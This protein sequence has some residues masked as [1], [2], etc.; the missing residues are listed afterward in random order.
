MIGAPPRSA[1]FPY[2]TLFRSDRDH[3]IRHRLRLLVPLRD[4]GRGSAGP[5]VR[6][7]I[8][9]PR[10]HLDAARTGRI[11][12]PA[13]HEAPWLAVPQPFDPGD[14][15]FAGRRFGLRHVGR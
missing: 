10:R 1:L 7:T 3:A 6:N 5:D 13:P 9:R 2:T 8:R 14:G 12:E 15:G 11:G 4:D